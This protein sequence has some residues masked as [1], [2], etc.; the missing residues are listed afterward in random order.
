MNVNLAEGSV[1]FSESDLQTITVFANSA[2]VAIHNNLLLREK[3]HQTRIQTMLEQMHSPQVVQELA[4][5]IGTLDQPNKIRE[6][7]YITVLFADIRGFSSIVSEV[8][9]EIIMDFLDE[10]YRVM[11]H[12]VFSFQGSID[13]FIGDEVMAYFGAPLKLENACQNGIDAARRMLL[14]FQSIVDKFAAHSDRF[15]KLGLGI[16]IH[17]G[18]AFVG[19]VGSWERYDYTVI[20]NTVNLARRLCSYAVSN[21]IAASSELCRN[22]EGIDMVEIER[23]LCFKGIA[24]PTDVYKINLVH[25]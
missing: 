23:D 19:N 21:Q 7:Q 6:I 10:F 3:L 25:C 2:A 18:E 11:T 20:G 8:E 5:K 15:I 13:K 9:P 24:R 4:K 1:I 12:T 22:V 17:A 14:D 16:G